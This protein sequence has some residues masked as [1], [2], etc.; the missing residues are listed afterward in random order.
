MAL[1]THRPLRL[2]GAQ[3]MGTALDLNDHDLERL[4]AK[5]A[6]YWRQCASQGNETYFSVVT[7]EAWHRLLGSEE[8]QA[9]LA[10]GASYVDIIKAC[11]ERFHPSP[12]QALTCMDF[13]CGVGRLAYWAAPH[14]KEIYGVDFSK[15]H[16]QEAQVNLESS[17]H[18][19]HFTGLFIEHLHNL[20]T[21]PKVDV[22]YSF[23]ALQH[24]TPPV[25]A[26]ILAYLLQALKPSGLALLHIP[27]AMP[28]YHFHFE[29]YMN[30]PLA[31][32][33]MEV[34]ILPK[35]DINRI[36][37]RYGCSIL[38]SECIGGVEAAYSENIVFQKKSTA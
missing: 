24:N 4:Y 27:L 36:A 38:H 20:S 17:E 6:G 37:E 33:N 1:D 29:E 12:S 16:L 13:G 5:T 11:W 31:G 30:D 3:V 7:D 26:K 18:G 21:L 28:D 25:I 22:C 19:G 35:A 8:K 2:D 10:S 9:F 23:I 14:F 15:T 34:H 32:T